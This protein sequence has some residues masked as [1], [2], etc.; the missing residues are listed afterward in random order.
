MGFYELGNN[1]H[2]L[3]LAHWHC[4]QKEN[5]SFCHRTFGLK[6]NRHIDGLQCHDSFISCRVKRIFTTVCLAGVGTGF[7]FAHCTTCKA[8][9]HLRVHV[10]AD[11]K[12]RTLKFRFFV[13]RDIIFIFLAVQLVGDCFIGIFGVSNR[14]FPAILAS[15]CM[16][17]LNV[18]V[19]FTFVWNTKKHLTQRVQNLDDKLLEQKKAAIKYWIQKCKIHG[20]L[21]GHKPHIT[22]PG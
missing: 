20:K 22:K 3:S 19:S 4:S 7:A 5:S 6:R 15:S 12:W 17:Y 9:Y 8:P 21:I 2:P 14:W 16:V 11:R 10:I 1:S 18:W 13:T